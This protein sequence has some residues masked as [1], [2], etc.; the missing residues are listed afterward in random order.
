[1]T[2]VDIDR[3]L[4]GCSDGNCKIKK[5]QGMHTNGGCRCLRYP[6]DSNAIFDSIRKEREK[7]L[8]LVQSLPDSEDPDAC[9]ICRSGKHLECVDGAAGNRCGCEFCC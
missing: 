4:M 8:H 1:M 7:L 6:D 2:K 3:F 9:D 5:P